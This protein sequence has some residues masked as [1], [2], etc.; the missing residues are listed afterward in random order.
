MVSFD[1][2]H[3]K[4]VLNTWGF[5]PSLVAKALPSLRGVGQ[6]LLG[7]PFKRIPN[8]GS[9]FSFGIIFIPLFLQIGRILLLLG[10]ELSV[11]LDDLILQVVLLINIAIGLTGRWV[12]LVVSHPS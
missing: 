3:K 2:G 7:E 4:E 11:D 1:Y 6:S 5:V 8:L 9:I 10:L 12:A